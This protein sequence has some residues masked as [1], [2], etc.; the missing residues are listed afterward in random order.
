MEPYRKLFDTESGHVQIIYSFLRY[1]SLHA[2]VIDVGAHSRRVVRRVSSDSDRFWPLETSSV[3]PAYL[4]AFI[5]AVH[6]PNCMRSLAFRLP[7]LLPWATSEAS[8]C[9]RLGRFQLFS[10]ISPR[11]FPFCKHTLP[12]THPYCCSS[13]VVSLCLLRA[14]ALCPLSLCLPLRPH[15]T[16]PV[17][18]EI[19]NSKTTSDAAAYARKQATVAV[20]NTAERRPLGLAR[21][22]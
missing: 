21:W 9:T 6:C 3:F 12:R 20:P 5:S 17:G 1:S 14:H 8:G 7:P 4:Q 22:P 10:L 18:V 15:S 2:S 19:A 11:L 13:I 16:P